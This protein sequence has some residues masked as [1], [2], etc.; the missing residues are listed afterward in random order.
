MAPSLHNTTLLEIV[1]IPL[2][3]IRT[4]DDSCSQV[5]GRLD[6]KASSSAHNDD[7]PVTKLGQTCSNA[8]CWTN[9]YPNDME[10][11]FLPLSS[12][13]NSEQKLHYSSTDLFRQKPFQARH[14]VNH[15]LLFLSWLSCLS[16]ILFGLFLGF[17]LFLFKH[18][19]AH[20]YQGLTSLLSIILFGC[21]LGR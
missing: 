7:D 9:V 18:A 10:P 6:L 14:S 13:G 1:P 17:I 12:K 8:V 15:L 20:G 21:S 5:A 11:P 4:H 2:F 16:L 19:T 3:K